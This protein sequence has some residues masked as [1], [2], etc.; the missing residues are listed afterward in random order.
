[1]SSDNPEPGVLRVRN[2]SSDAFE[3]RVQGWSY[4]GSLHGPERVFY[5][6]TEPGMQSLGGLVVEAGHLQSSMVLADGRDDVAYA[7]PFA[8]VPG[9]F[10]SVMTQNATEPVTVRVADRDA[11]GFAMAMQPE[12][13]AAGGHPVETLG[14]VAIQAG[15]GVTTDGRVVS[16]FD[17]GVDHTPLPVPFGETLQGRFPSILAQVGSALGLD[18]VVVRYSDLSPDDVT[19]R[20]QEEQSQDDETGHRV[21]DVSLFVGE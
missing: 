16:V 13:A 6:V 14:W 5:L 17:A 7:L 21:E 19:L 20:I 10:A 2:A 12:D 3:L 11:N 1:M 9:V 4:L 15:R 18:A 8:D